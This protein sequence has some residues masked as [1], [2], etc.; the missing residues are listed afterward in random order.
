M[1]NVLSPGN[2]L[3]YTFNM[4]IILAL[5]T[6]ICISAMIFLNGSL[7]SYIGNYPSLLFIHMSGFILI[8]LMFLHKKEPKIR[9][10][11]SRWY[12]LAGVMGIAVVTLN[13]KVFSMGG[14]LLAL[15]G[16]LT[17][18]VIMALIM[19]IIKNKRTQTTLPLGKIISLFLVIPGAVIIGARSGLPYYWI[20]LSWI[21]GIMVML[22]SFMN[23]QNILS[24][25]F[26]KTLIVHYGSTLVIL[27]LMLSFMP[28]VSA[29]FVKVFSGDVPIP[30]VIG[31]GS[32]AIFVVSIG[33]YLLLK[34]K[35]I[36]YV[37]L[38]YSGQL[39]GAILIDY[40]QGLPIS[41]EKTVA[42]ILIILGLFI[43]E[44]KLK[45]H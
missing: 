8:S 15:S 5:I 30:F 33:S 17:G 7:E 35:P 26:R 14:V 10:R 40:T 37:L 24:L 1:T 42:M 3:T 2:N 41:I 29:A 25:G 20:I 38:L 6:G 9:E 36:S 32:V 16:T 27:L 21:P 12:L 28:S 23:S 22:Q 19:E 45:R 43:G 39:S 13:N 31:G 18:Q 11:R 4:N 34:L 44:I